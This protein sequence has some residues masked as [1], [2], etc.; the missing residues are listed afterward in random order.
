[1]EPFGSIVR[2][3]ELIMQKKVE[4]E[5]PKVP[6]TIS[7]E[8]LFR[9]GLVAHVLARV[10]LGE[11]RALVIVETTGMTH[12]APGTGRARTVA[13]RTLYRWLAAFSGAGIDALEPKKRSRTDASVVLSPKLLAFLQAE[14]TKDKDASIPEML[15]RARE[16]SVIA[17]DARIH[18][19][20]VHRAL[21][22]MG[23]PITRTRGKRDTDMRRFA[24]AFRMRMVLV[25]GKH[26]RAGA[27]RTKRVAFFFID[28][29]TRLILAVVVGA[30]EAPGLLL[31][32]L[33][34]VI[35]RYGLM[36]VLYFD[37]GPGFNADDVRAVCAR[38]E[39]R[40]IHGKSAYPE[41]HGKV[42]RFN[43]TAWADC[44]RG[45]CTPE[46]DASLGALDLRLLHYVDTQYNP[47]THDELQGMSPRER[48]DADERPLR[49]PRSHDDLHERFFVSEARTVSADNIVSVDGTLYE[50]PR[51]HARTRVEIRRHTL[52]G[53]LCILHEGKLV[54]LH[55]VD[56]AANAQSARAQV[57]QPRV[58][59][60]AE[61][62]VTAASLAFDRDFGR[63]TDS[64]GG[65]VCPPKTSAK[66]E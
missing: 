55:P 53:N 19:A 52:N 47:R 8:A 50:V 39:V 48:W 24:F 22:R 10:A 58:D 14:K 34:E 33:F 11:V 21:V 59:D 60:T 65:F 30:S 7:A 63:V 13:G 29:C 25:D 27:Y 4:V 44:L 18:R 3:E 20:T 28:D 6:I 1:M 40:P 38:L 31:R 41:G 66:K 45:L 26:F 37:R 64:S 36:D 56:L 42:E 2:S 49:F 17:K 5:L 12:Q 32:G 54:R 57:P 16:L 23:V 62:P 35:R 61:P 43:R 51:G 46:V 9:Y 15:R